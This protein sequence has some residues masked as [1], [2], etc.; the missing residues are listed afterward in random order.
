MSTDP[1]MFNRDYHVTLTCGCTTL[2]RNQPLTDRVR[3][4]CST[5]QGHGY[6]LSWVSWVNPVIGASAINQTENADA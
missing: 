2:S 1:R 5:G 3:F 4:G 6:R